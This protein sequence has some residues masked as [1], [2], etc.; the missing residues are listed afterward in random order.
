MIY[1]LLKDYY[2][3]PNMRKK[4]TKWTVKCTIYQQVK[5]DYR[6]LVEELQPLLVPG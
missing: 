6:K 4:I 1:T 3:L 5:T 2:W